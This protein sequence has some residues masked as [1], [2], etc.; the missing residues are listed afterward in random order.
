MLGIQNPKFQLFAYVQTLSHETLY[1]NKHSGT[2]CNPRTLKAEVGESWVQG[3]VSLHS[4]F[5]GSLC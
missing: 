3:K 5:H 1:V 4:K 2:Y